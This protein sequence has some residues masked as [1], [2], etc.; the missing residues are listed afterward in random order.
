MTPSPRFI[1]GV[2][3]FEGR[4]FDSPIPLN[5]AGKYTVP[6][7]KR[8][9]PIYVRGGNSSDQLVCVFLVKD[10][11]AIRYFPIGARSDIHVPLAVVED[12]FPETELELQIAAPKATSGVVIIDFGL[13]EID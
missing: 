10:G 13:Y 5:P 12:M 11:K 3:T 1:Q 8:A 4:G 6:K 2:F 7:D 9:Q